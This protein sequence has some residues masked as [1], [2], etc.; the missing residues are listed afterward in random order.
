MKLSYT[1]QSVLLSI[2][3]F[4]ISRKLPFC[5]YTSGATTSPRNNKNHKT[6]KMMAILMGTYYGLYLPRLISI[7]IPYDPLI[8][9]HIDTILTTILFLNALINAIIYAW[10]SPDFNLAFR[11]I[12]RFKCNDGN[13]SRITG[14]V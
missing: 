10:M 8:K 14:R 13:S 9:T 4:T 3:T 6:T 11:T 12:L 7:N 5:H 1:T 2:T